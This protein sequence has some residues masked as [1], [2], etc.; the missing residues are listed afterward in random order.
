MAKLRAYLGFIE[1]YVEK[2]L[3][4]V[5]QEDILL[6]ADNNDWTIVV[7]HT[8]YGP[9][10]AKAKCGIAYREHVQAH[11]VPSSARVFCNGAFDHTVI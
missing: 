6:G 2:D 11:G 9:F 1:V 5:S 10:N 3:S 8:T 7:D 4:P